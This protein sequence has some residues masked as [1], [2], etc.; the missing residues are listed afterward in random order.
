MA[1]PSNKEVQKVLQEIEGFYH[2]YNLHS[3]YDNPDRQEFYNIGFLTSIPPVG[4]RS[5]WLREHG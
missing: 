2:E 5:E 3:E 4:G 1:T